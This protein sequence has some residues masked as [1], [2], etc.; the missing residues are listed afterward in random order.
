MKEIDLT[1]SKI[2]RTSRLSTIEFTKTFPP[3]FQRK[4][5]FPLLLSLSVSGYTT[6]LNSSSVGLLSSNGY[7]E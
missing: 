2:C 6:S 3:F 4:S 7:V 1:F 5:D